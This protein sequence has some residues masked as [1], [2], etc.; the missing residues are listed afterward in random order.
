M[1]P[2][3]RSFCPKHLNAWTAFSHEQNNQVIRYT[4]LHDLLLRTIADV[5]EE[6]PVVA[7][8]QTQTA[9]AE[10][11]DKEIQTNAASLANRQTQTARVEQREE[12]TQTDA[13]TLVDQTCQTSTPAQAD[14]CVQT[15][16]AD[17]EDKQVQ[18]TWPA[19]TCVFEVVEMETV[20]TMTEASTISS[21][22]TQTEPANQME[23]LLGR[24][25]AEG[26]QAGYSQGLAAG[27]TVAFMK[28]RQEAK[29]VGRSEDKK[30]KIEIKPVATPVKAVS[31]A[32]D[33][34]KGLFE[35]AR[36]SVTPRK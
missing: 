15:P 7:D 4:S 25:R 20:S 19:N 1:D 29:P 26:Y 8:Q 13:A 32:N 12:E 31:A 30:E 22:T 21:S 35:V 23:D 3:A 17:A 2:R 28:K 9:A 24:A 11:Q 27:K 33:P 5:N 36:R 10:Q 14:R 16:T 34:F 18:T 6:A